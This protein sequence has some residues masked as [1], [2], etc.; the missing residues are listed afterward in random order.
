MLLSRHVCAKTFN[1]TNVTTLATAYQ[2]AEHG[3][4]KVVGMTVSTTSAG[5]GLIFSSKTQLNFI[6]AYKNDAAACCRRERHLHGAQAQH[7][8]DPGAW[9]P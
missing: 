5:T 6:V 9:Q 1:L 7:Q 2:H 8:H 4:L 3:V